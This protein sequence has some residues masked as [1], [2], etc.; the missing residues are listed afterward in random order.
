[1]RTALAIAKFTVLLA[2]IIGIP[3][4]I[5]LKY[6]NV[7][8]EFKD[9]DNIN[10]LLEEYHTHSMFI[11]IGLQVVQ[12]II[13]FLPGQPL[14]FAAGYA[15]SFPLAL[16]L[17]LIGITIG[18]VITFYLARIFGKDLVYLVFGKEKLHRFI[19]LLNS[20]KAYIAVFLLYL[21]PGIPKDIF[22]YAAGISEMKM[23]PFT[24]ISLI[25]RTPAL[26]VS[27]LVGNMLYTRSYLGIIIVAIIMIIIAAACAVKRKKVYAMVDRV[28]NRFIAKNNVE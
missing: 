7:I 21:F 25:G 2:V 24:I 12:I 9:I 10:S 3:L 23:M 17:S 18:T 26:A 15:F 1:V 13:A 16:L 4:L 27:L 8:Q 20:K 19:K 6:P 28:Y 5:L 11:Y 22:S 14:Q